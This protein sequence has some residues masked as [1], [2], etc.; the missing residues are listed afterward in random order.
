LGLY[1]KAYDLFVLPFSL[2]TVY[3]VAVSTLSRLNHDRAQYKRYVLGGLT[4]LALVGM[5]IGANLTL[6]GKDLVRLMLGPQWEAAGRIFTLFG[7]GIGLMLI[8][9]TNGMI[10]L[11]IGTT[12]RFFR[13]GIVESVV[14]ILL[15]LLTL[16]WGPQGIAAAWT[17]SYCILIVPAFWYAGKPIQLGVG[18]VLSVIWRCILASLLA[19]CASAA[20]LR[21]LPALVA[22]P[23]ALGAFVRIVATSL[24]FGILYVGAVILLHGGC[25]PLYKLF[26]LLREMLPVGKAKKPSQVDGT[27]SAPDSLAALAPT[28]SQ[29]LS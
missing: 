5:G 25:A 29:E 3:P 11:S 15:F 12:G 1:K 7:P 18:S 4:V 8:Y 27:L 19:G 16:R 23:G 21:A 2:L 10:H 14:T 17:A 20:I 9:S 24:V 26:G 13:W 6:A 22:F 28:A